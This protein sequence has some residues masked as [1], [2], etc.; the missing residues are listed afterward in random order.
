MYEAAANYNPAA[1]YDDMS[2]DFSCAVQGC[3]DSAASNFDANA[4]EDNGSCLY[5]GCTSIGA[6]NYNSNAF[7]DDG[8]C[9]FAGCMNELACNYDTSATS[10]DGS[11]LIVGCMDPDGLNY[12]AGANFP[13]GCDYPDACPGDINGDL[14][15]DVSDLLTFFQYYGT[16]CPE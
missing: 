9:E 10:D 3:T 15:I 5:A 14:F 12:D 6:T 11:C 1:T 7:G 16:A 4:E 8:S 2:C 13:G